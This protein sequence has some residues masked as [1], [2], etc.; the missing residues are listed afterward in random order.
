V[1]RIFLEAQSLLEDYVEVRTLID[2]SLG[3]DREVILEVRIR[4]QQLEYLAG[5]V[6]ELEQVLMDLDKMEKFRRKVEEVLRAAIERVHPG[7]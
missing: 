1:E 7:G 6:H 4:L 3:D 2:P 5:K